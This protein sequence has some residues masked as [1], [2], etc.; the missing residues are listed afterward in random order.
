MARYT[1]ILARA[2]HWPSPEETADLVYAARVHDVGKIF[3][4]ER[5]LNKPGPLTDDEFPGEECTRAWARK[6]SAIPPHSA[7]MRQAIEHHHQ[8]FDGTAIPMARG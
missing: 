7:M 2:C 8:R 6:L 1:E 4:P 5:I 3:V